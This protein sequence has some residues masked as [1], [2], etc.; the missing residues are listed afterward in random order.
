M[1][2]D[3]PFFDPLVVD[4][5]IVEYLRNDLD[6]ATTTGRELYPPGLTGEVVSVESL[7]NIIPKLD[8]YDKEH[9]TSFY[10]RNCDNFR[11]KYIQAPD[12]IQ[13]NSKI[14]LVVDDERDLARARWIASHITVMSSSISYMHQVALLAKQWDAAN[15]KT[16]F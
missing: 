1:C 15:A 5:L 7:K 6:L 16:S 12:Y 2:G 10:Y 4:N 13:A 14:R 9:L 11:I 8:A 3:R